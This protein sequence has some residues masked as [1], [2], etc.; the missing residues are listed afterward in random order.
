MSKGH[1]VH[2]IPV[3][4]AEPLNDHRVCLQQRERRINWDRLGMLA[5]LACGIHCL[6]LPVAM[7]LLLASG[8]EFVAEPWFELLISLSIFFIALRTLRT[9]WHRGPLD[10]ISLGLL[11]GL[12]LLL[13]GNLHSLFG[14]HAHHHRGFELDVHMLIP[15][16]ALLIALCNGLDWWKAR[17]QGCAH[18]HG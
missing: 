16:G 17:H 10:P 1:S 9:R 3:P 18:N 8:W 5:S 6:A 4:S 15:A 12:G 11:A 7:P 2:E 13:A 14:N